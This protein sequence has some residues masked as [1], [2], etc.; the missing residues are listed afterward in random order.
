MR[1]IKDRITS[2]SSLFNQTAS[3]S[4]QFR[5]SLESLEKTNQFIFFKNKTIYRPLKK[6]LMAF[7]EGLYFVHRSQKQRRNTS[8]KK[9]S[10]NTHSPKPSPLPKTNENTKLP[11][12]SLTQIKNHRTGTPVITKREIFEVENMNKEKKK[13]EFLEVL[14]KPTKPKIIIK[15][16]QRGNKCVALSQTMNVDEYLC[17]LD[18]LNPW[19]YES[20]N[21]A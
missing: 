21:K 19:D 3:F 9:T 4:D 13:N 6:P 10:S 12:S 7:R 5:K 8:N 17:D 1:S 18:A 11:N 20:I 16:K 14:N 15:R 2:N